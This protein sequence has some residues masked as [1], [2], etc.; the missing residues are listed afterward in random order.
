MFGGSKFWYL[1]PRRPESHRESSIIEFLGSGIFAQI[2]LIHH[3]HICIYNCVYIYI[4][5]ISIYTYI[6]IYIYV[7]RPKRID[8]LETWKWLGQI[9]GQH[10]AFFPPGIYPKY[11]MVKMWW[12]PMF[13]G[14][15]YQFMKFGLPFFLDGWKKSPILPMSWPWHRWLH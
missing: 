5:Y 13:L 9:R 2:L 12:V 14:D 4:Y 11:A 3:P 15:G 7:A 10:L 8:K 1:G 6:Y